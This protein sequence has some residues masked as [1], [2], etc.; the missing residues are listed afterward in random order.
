MPHRARAG[1]EAEARKGG[2]EEDDLTQGQN[3][4]RTNVVRKAIGKMSAPQLS[5]DS[6][7]GPKQRGRGQMVWGGCQPAQQPCGAPEN[8]FIGLATMG[9]YEED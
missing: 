3:W 4:D 8:D 1:A 2:K 6:Q 9:D 5:D 7:S